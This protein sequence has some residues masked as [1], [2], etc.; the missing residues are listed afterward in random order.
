MLDTL[1]L[2]DEDQKETFLE[3][4]GY[5]KDSAGYMDEVG[6][7]SGNMGYVRRTSYTAMSKLCSLEGPLGV[8]LA[9]QNRLIPNGVAL[10]FKLYPTSDRFRLMCSGS[11]R[12]KVDIV[13][14]SLKV[15]EIDVN[16]GIL[17]GHAAAFEKSP[18]IY[19]F[20]RS[21]LKT[22]NIAKG[23]YDFSEENIF[24]SAI[25]SKVIV[26][27]VSSAGFNGHYERNP[28]NF[29]NFN[30]NYIDFK[31]DNVS[32]PGSALKPDFDA[33]NIVSSYLSMFTLRRKHGF[34]GN[35][36]SRDDFSRGY[37]IYG[38]Q[39]SSK[40]SD[41]FTELQRSGRSGIYMTFKRPLP[42]P[43]TVIVYGQFPS[44]MEIDQARNILL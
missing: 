28:Y 15:F 13:N 18:A 32:R 36:I 7:T 25:P 26:A 44:Y 12:Y 17:I 39:L 42:E 29:A 20:M 10:H 6:L 3:S 1:L 11:E 41:N 4:E 14:A 5:D 33:E 21:E 40:Q 37:A 30:L 23:N 24:Q 16:P 38:F 34:E 19:P 8:D 31:V 43:V 35:Y 9:S 2:Y 27:L 22:F